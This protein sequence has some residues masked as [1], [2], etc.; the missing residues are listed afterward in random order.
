M[1]LTLERWCERH[2][3]LFRF[4]IGT[5]P[6]V[7]VADPS[8]INAILRDR[9]EGFR[10]WR[11]VQ[12]VLVEMTVDGVFTAE[13]ADWRR[14]R[15]LAVTALNS[16]HLYRYYDVI[17]RATERLHRRLDAAARTGEPLAIDREFASY[18][19]DVTSAL[20]F[21]HDLN[22]L[23]R[24]EHDL[25]RHI[26]AVF[27][28][29][30]RRLS[31]PFAYWR[32]L[33]L[34][35]DRSLDRSLAELSVAVSGFVA[36]A[37]ARM[38]ERPELAERPENFL[39]GM[40]AAQ[41]TEG[42]FSE[43]ELLGNT[44][45]MLLAGEDTTS[46]TLSWTIW[47]LAHERAVQDRLAGEAAGLLADARCPS[48]HSVADALRYG[49][50][51]LRESMRLKSVAPIIFLETIADTTIGDVRVPAGMPVF[52]L[53]RHA[54]LQESYFARAHAFEPDR[55]SNGAAHTHDAK[56]FLPFGAGPRFCPGRNLAMLEAKAALAMFARNFEVTLDESR[57][58]VRERFGF[59]M[60]PEGLR[61]RLRPR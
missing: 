47:F 49:E 39:E 46:H 53:T 22:R 40:L 11:Q 59:T 26:A 35:A 24:D 25:Q 9:P 41:R 54:A 33:R 2:G 29:V 31:L 37:R 58:R 21:G 34:P 60:A 52:L 20:A 8:A 23:E 10:R 13:G 14:Q 15:R 12:D 16:N 55:W 19:V 44:L 56:A 36:D 57:G 61:V 38:D 43:T 7:G 1:H 27:R 18:T 3:P 28:M 32:W 42:R 30:A 6:V 48:E 4:D 17:G 5:R 45:T 51:V 50:A